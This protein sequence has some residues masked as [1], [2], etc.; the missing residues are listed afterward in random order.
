MELDI[1]RFFNEAAPQDYSASAVELGQNAG[2]IT[3]GHAME[4]AHVYQLLDTDEKLD[5]FRAFVKSSGGWSQDEILA[6]TDTELEALAIQWV[7]GDIREAGLSPA[8][9]DADWD[10]YQALAERGTVSSRLFR[11]GESI[12]FSLD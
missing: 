2:Q 5:A 8:S 10:E 9:T 4:D 7:S 6:F 3:W 11:S 1:T 12:Y